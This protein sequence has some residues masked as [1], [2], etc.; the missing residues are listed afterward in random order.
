[1]YTNSI[2]SKILSDFYFTLDF[3]FFFFRISMAS[4]EIWHWM[5]AIQR[6]YNHRYRVYGT[7]Y[8]SDILFLL[9]FFCSL[10]SRSLSLVL[11]KMMMKGAFHFVSKCLTLIGCV[12]GIE[13]FNQNWNIWLKTSNIYRL[14]SI[15]RTVHK[16][17]YKISAVA[18]QRK[19]A[20]LSQ[21]KNQ[22]FISC[23]TIRYVNE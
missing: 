3:F 16:R 10:A 7:I 6:T 9:I 22:H 23:D 12:E 18:S 11:R 21:K 20:C 8:W 13:H 19:M 4:F 14:N 15:H 2:Y 17:N 1:M 5:R